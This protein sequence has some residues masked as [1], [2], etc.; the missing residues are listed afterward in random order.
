MFQCP[1]IKLCS[2]YKYNEIEGT[3]VRRNS[4]P[5]TV[6]EPLKHRYATTDSLYIVLLFQLFN[7][8]KS[9][10]PFRFEIK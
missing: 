3:T 2:N 8:F 4:V 9:C 5:Q 10:Y 1:L 7:I 6:P